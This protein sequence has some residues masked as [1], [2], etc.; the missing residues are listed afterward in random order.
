MKDLRD[1]T[2]APAMPHKWALGYMQS[3]RELRDATFRF[4]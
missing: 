2:G 3:H 1:L 4:G